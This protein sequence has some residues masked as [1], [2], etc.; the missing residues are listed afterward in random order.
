MKYKGRSGICNVTPTDID[1]A[2]RLEIENCVV[3]FELKRYGEMPNGQRCALVDM[4]DLMSRGGADCILF[5]AQHDTDDD[6][7]II[8]KDSIVTE[9]YWKGQWW[10][11]K[12]KYTLGEFIDKYISYLDSK[13]DSISLTQPE[14]S[15]C[16]GCNCTKMERLEPCEDTISR[17][18]AITL[19]VMPKEHREYQ[20]HNLDDAYEQGWNDLQKCI[21]SLPSTQPE[22]KCSECDAWNKYKNYPREPHWIPCSERL[23]KEDTDVLVTYVNGEETR[24][25]PVNYGHSTWYDCVF[26]TTLD[27]LKVTAWMPLP[28]P[29][30]ERR[31]DG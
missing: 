12:D 8:A 31:T 16:W 11:V 18:A 27:P 3:L 29:Y 7:I 1:G 13:L 23:P 21:E 30:A 2:M 17:H 14:P 10:D 20:T 25:A 6:E 9:V 15:Q 5:V 28:E 24:I 4:V 22:D 19:P 26:E